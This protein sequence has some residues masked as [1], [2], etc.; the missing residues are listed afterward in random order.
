MA[1]VQK[2]RNAKGAKVQELIRES[3]EA[4]QAR[5]ETLEG[6]AQKLIHEV[7][8]RVQKVS[9]K[10]WK[11][12][13]GQVDKLRRAGRDAAEEWKDKAQN[14][15]GE[16]VDRLL[17]L[18]VRA[19][20]FLGVATREE[21]EDLSREIGKILKRLD[22]VQKRRVRRTARKASEAQA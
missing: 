16:A 13:R 15:R 8:A 20:K 12:F 4:A 19:M 6:D 11:E 9:K 5:L 10:D 21:V 14:F 1:E 18:Q 2:A 3:I 22:E 17:E 7:S